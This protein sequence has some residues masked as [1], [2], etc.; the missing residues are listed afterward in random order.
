M[1]SDESGRD[2]QGGEWDVVVVGGGGSGL[3]AAIEAR[4]LGRRVVLLERDS[5]LGG[6]TGRSIG[7]FTANN[8]PQQIRDGIKDSPD[9][10]YEDMKRFCEQSPRIH[11]QARNVPDNDEL[12]RFFVDNVT[13]T[14]NWIS[15][16]GVVFYGPLPEPP[17]RRP[18]MHNVLPNSRAYI[19]HLERRARKIGVEIK[20][21]MRA[22]ELM[23]EQD[24]VTGIKCET[25]A[26]QRHAF[27]ARG[28]VVLTTGDF[29][30]D[31]DMRARHLPSLTDVQPVN[32][33]NSGDGHRMVLE[34]GGRLIDTGLYSAGIR[35]QAP[36]PSWITRLPP[37]RFFT[38]IMDW[39]MRSLPDWLLRPV[40]MSFLTTILVPSAKLFKAGAV[41]VNKHGVRFVNEIDNPADSGRPALADQPDQM[42]YIIFDARVSRQFAQW[43]YYVSTAPGVAYAYVPDYRRT[44]PDVFHEAKTI[45]ELAGKIGVE[46]SV[47]EET[48]NDFNASL[49][50]GDDQRK[51][52]TEGP[53]VA[54]GPVRF[55]LNFSD[56][57]IAVDTQMRVLGADDMPVQGLFAAGFTGMGGV[58]LEGHGH[59]IAWAFTSGRFAGRHAANTVTTP[60]DPV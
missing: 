38:R 56:S 8:T 34:L 45:G 20:T 30:A 42:G 19:Y 36:P 1:R 23:V 3:A 52:M 44:R 4:S 54:M 59:H 51:P 27:R 47:L 7:S 39:S 12:R 53:F 13:D 29:S 6:S 15:E 49:P 18:R 25:P 26:G 24:R 60:A 31:R 33:H 17:H 22:V 40:V 5:R 46:R 14:F 35:F 37:Q 2:T 28:G 50:I 48:V 32:P 55:F 57:G 58:L 16:M 41:L 11:R 43:P 21:S 10:H 9:E